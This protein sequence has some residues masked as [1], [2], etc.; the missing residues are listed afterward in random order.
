VVVVVGHG[1]VVAYV[2]IPALEGVRMS[3]QAGQ[4]HL[5]GLSRDMEA[6]ELRMG[7]EQKPT[8]LDRAL[9]MLLDKAHVLVPQLLRSD[10]VGMLHMDSEPDIQVEAELGY[11][12]ID[13]HMV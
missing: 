3:I 6:L 1:Q 9:Q 13:L 12:A 2:H 4:V 8:M 5:V 7:N 11:M 10:L